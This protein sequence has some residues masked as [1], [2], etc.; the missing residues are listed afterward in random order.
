MADKIIFGFIEKKLHKVR[1][2]KNPCTENMFRVLFNTKMEKLLLHSIAP[3]TAQ[4]A[5]GYNT[6]THT[7]PHTLTY[8]HTHTARTH[9][10]T[11][12]HTQTRAS[13]HKH[14]HTRTDIYV[15]KRLICDITLM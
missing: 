11:H 5:Q 9:T 6:R 3:S 2:V 7:T 14:T 4:S 10:H 1:F 15:C 13:T 8:T 12:T